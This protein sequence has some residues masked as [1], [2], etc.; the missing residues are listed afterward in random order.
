[1]YLAGSYVQL[2]RRVHGN[3]IGGDEDGQLLGGAGITQRMRQDQS[4]CEVES[5]PPCHTGRV[6]LTWKVG[7][8]Q[9]QLLHASQYD[10]RPEHGTKDSSSL[11]RRHLRHEQ[12]W[13]QLTR[14]AAKLEPER[15][16]S[17][18]DAE[19]GRWLMLIRGGLEQIHGI[20]EFHG[21]PERA[22]AG[23]GRYE[24]GRVVITATTR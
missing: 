9:E 19:A 22:G 21:D 3:A 18:L 6:K 15:R 7:V 14:G 24:S 2:G 4:T 8:V 17:I 10:T 12:P 13:P 23:R 11:S 20:S 5:A 16:L 1:M